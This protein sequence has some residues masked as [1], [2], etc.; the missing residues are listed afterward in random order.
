MLSLIIDMRQLKKIRLEPLFKRGYFLLVINVWVCHMNRIFVAIDLRSNIEAIL[1]TAKDLARAYDSEIVLATVEKELP[2]AE[3][4]EEGE[5]MDDLAESY[6]DDVH[7]LHSL[8]RSVESEG[9]NCRALILEGVAANQLVQAAN[10]LNADLLILGN[11]GHS[12]LYD[13]LIGGT[14]P[15][16]IQFAKQKVLLVPLEE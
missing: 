11:H 3:G 10:D 5:V 16:V 6:G 4:A 9:F 2:G 1:E 14:A 15:G 12:P 8:A 7:E 13:T